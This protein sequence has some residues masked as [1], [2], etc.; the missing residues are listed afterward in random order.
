MLPYQLVEQ[1]VFEKVFYPL[2]T[3]GDGW[4]ME[5]GSFAFHVLGGGDS[6]YCSVEGGATVTAADDDG[7]AVPESTL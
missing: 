2:A 3:D 6:S 4:E 1:T 7:L 5:D